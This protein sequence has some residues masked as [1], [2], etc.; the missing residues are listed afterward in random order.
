MMLQ[1]GTLLLALAGVGL[2]G[3]AW[4]AEGTGVNGTAGALLALIGAVGALSGLAVLATA[5]P[6]GH[7]RR[8]VVGLAFLAALLTAVAGWFLM[9]DAL[10]IVMALVAVAIPFAAAR[11]SLRAAAR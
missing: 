9:Q 2:A 11:P 1:F 5:Q 7:S 10:A 6:T 3:Y 4:T 8:L